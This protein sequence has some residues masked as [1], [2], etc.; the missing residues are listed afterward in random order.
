MSGLS[1]LVSRRE[2]FASTDFRTT[3]CERDCGQKCRVFQEQKPDS[4]EGNGG[5][6]VSRLE[7]D[8]HKDGGSQPTDSSVSHR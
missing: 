5:I 2:A 3:D 4:G 1:G 7:S 8:G 6:G